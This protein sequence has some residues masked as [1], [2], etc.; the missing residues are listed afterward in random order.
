VYEVP[1]ARPVAT[2]LAALAS[3][4]QITLAQPLQEFLTRTDSGPPY[5]DPLYDMHTN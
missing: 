2:V 5:N 4:P 3:D 1:D